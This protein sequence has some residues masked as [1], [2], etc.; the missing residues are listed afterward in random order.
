MNRQRTLLLTLVLILAL[1]LSLA[2]CK[3]EKPCTNH[4]DDDMNGVCDNC[5]GAMP[6]TCETHYD[7]DMDAVCDFCDGAITN[8]ITVA[9]ALELCGEVSN[10]TDERYYIRATVDNITDSK[11]GAMIIS[12]DTGSISVYGTYSFDGALSFAALPEMPKKGDTVLL[13][14][15]LQ[16]YKGDKEVKN[17]RLVGFVD[18]SS[19]FDASQYTEATIAEARDMAKGS[20]VIVEGVVATKTYSTG[21]K[22][23]GV[24]LV[25]D[26]Q[27]IYVYDAALA[28]S[29]SVGNK[30]KIAAEKDFWILE[31]EE[32]NAAKYGYRGCN[33][34]TNAYVLSNDG[35]NNK[36]NTAWVPE[37]TVMDILETPV[38]EDITTSLYK[39]TA[40]V[41]KS[42][43]PGFVNYYINDLDGET[44]TYVYTQCS[45]GDFAWLDQ[46]D[47]KICTVYIT[48]LNAKSTATGCV[49]RFLPVAVAAI[50][51]FSFADESVPAHVMK[52]Y[53]MKQ[54]S[55]KYSGDPALE[56]ITSVSSELLGFTGASVSYSSSN[57]EVVSFTAS[58][59]TVTMNCP[60]YGTATV[61]VTVSYKGITATETLE[62]TVEEPLSIEFITVAEAVAAD[63]DS[64]VTVK[65]IVGASLVNQVG[66]YL[67]D[68]SG[69]IAVQ[70]NADAF[71]SIS[72]G[73]EVILRGKRAL[74]KDTQ[75]Y[76]SDA[77]ILANF[78]GDNALPT[79]SYTETD[80]NTAFASTD[81]TKVLVTRAVITKV[82][83]GYSINYYITDPA[84]EDNKIQIYSSGEKGLTWLDTLLGQELT[85]ELIKCNWNGK[86]YKFAVIS[87]ITA[88]G[89]IYSS[90]NFDNYGN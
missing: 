45:G 47:G 21:I 31:D 71:G 35:G 74:K 68:E 52:Y 12:D 78:Y 56:L 46:Y 82:G 80:I 75:I 43:E 15:V 90:Y 61:T 57:N 49:F 18:N 73:D 38:T 86:G 83:G 6:P 65:G 72:I 60:G 69:A 19:L 50:N 28:G 62:V 37:S 44:G 23:A 36:L 26:T 84:D 24:I 5:G 17:A 64:D 25:D 10:V 32:A 29:A 40:L 1:V 48:A 8:V 30:V 41:V 81:T 53:A 20:L 11:Y 34:L 87:V 16:N 67:I 55:A 51:D 70:I 14:C 85:L 76:I 63:V 89:K 4:T 59:D 58:G 27:S 39:V 22:P 13:H 88:D 54:L 79:S 66:F 2:A 3:N 42:E 77:E 33:Q 7:P 9:E